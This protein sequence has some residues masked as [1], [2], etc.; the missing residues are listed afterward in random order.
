MSPAA[1]RL[2]STYDQRTVRNGLCPQ[3]ELPARDYFWLRVWSTTAPPSTP[4]FWSYFHTPQDLVEY[5]SIDGSEHQCPSNEFRTIL[6]PFST[7]VER[8]VSLTSGL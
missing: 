7:D 5:I 8:V 6:A 2:F 3:F 4:L 1:P